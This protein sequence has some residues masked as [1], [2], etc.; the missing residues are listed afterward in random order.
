MNYQAELQSLTKSLGIADSILQAAGLSYPILAAPRRALSRVSKAANRPLRLAVL[1]ETNSGKSS[2]ANMIVG[3]ITLPALP[4]ANT[5]LPTLLLYAPSPYAAALQS[6]GKRITLT[7]AGTV[8]PEEVLRLEVGLPSEI[9]RHVEILDFPGS[10]NPLFPTDVLAVLRHRVDSAIWV[11]A[12]TQAWRET[13]RAAWLGLP[14]KFRSRGLL[15]VTHCDL[16]ET[17]LDL[18][19]LRSRLEAAAKPQF[20]AM[21]FVS[22]ASGNPPHASGSGAAELL[23]E[24]RQQAQNFSIARLTK[25]VG[26]TRRIAEKTL[27]RLDPHPEMS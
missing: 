25:A 6:S 4:V 7:P 23:T 13:E 18:K 22:A 27:V 20:Q 1:G 3:D 24:V 21:C 10:A 15:A 9:L 11:T 16:I 2:L 5:R 19:R 8:L 12:A 14:S 26:I 17:E